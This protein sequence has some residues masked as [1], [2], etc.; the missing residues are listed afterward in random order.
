MQNKSNISFIR[1]LNRI[2]HGLYIIF[3]LLFLLLIVA[4]IIFII[5]YI[6]KT[7]I[8]IDIFPRSHILEILF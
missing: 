5:L 6:L 4:L 7:F 2:G 3:G 1:L 8:G